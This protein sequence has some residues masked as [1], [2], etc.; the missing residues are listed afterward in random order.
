MHL[1]QSD[2]HSLITARPPDARAEVDAANR[3]GL[4]K[5]VREKLM[6][7]DGVFQPEVREPGA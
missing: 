7:R 6:R 4:P 3:T 5:R 1:Q 2:H